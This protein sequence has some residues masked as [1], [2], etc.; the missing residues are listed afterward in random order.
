MPVNSLNYISLKPPN[1][2]L[3]QF[4][5]SFSSPITSLQLLWNSSVGT[6]E[7]LFSNAFLNYLLIMLF[8]KTF[9]QPVPCQRKPILVITSQLFIHYLYIIYNCIYRQFETQPGLIFFLVC[10]NNIIY[11][12]YIYIF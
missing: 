6:Q 5:H 10:L 3:V 8:E 2:N 9:A 7:R 11:F 4:K 1:E 12:N